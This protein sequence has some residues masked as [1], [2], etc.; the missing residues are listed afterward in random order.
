MLFSVPYLQRKFSQ[1]R[2]PIAINNNPPPTIPEKPSASP[3]RHH[4][5][6]VEVNGSSN[7]AML[8][9]VAGV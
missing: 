7:V 9:T 5:N 6:T 8:A 4:A 1:S 2:I 3:N